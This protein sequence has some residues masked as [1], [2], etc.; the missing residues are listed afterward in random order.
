[1]PLSYADAL[2]AEV[3]AKIGQMM[4]EPPSGNPEEVCKRFWAVLRSL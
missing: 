1:V 3:M 2:G 4:K